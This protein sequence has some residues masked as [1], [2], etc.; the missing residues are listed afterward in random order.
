MKLKFIA[1]VMICTILASLCGCSEYTYL[2]TVKDESLFGDYSNESETVKKQLSLSDD[3]TYKYDIYQNNSPKTEFHFDGN[4]SYQ[5]INS[6]ITRIELD[7]ISHFDNGV[8]FKYKNLIG[9]YTSI[10]CDFNDAFTIPTPRDPHRFFIFDGKNTAT[11]NSGTQKSYPY[12]I[13]DD[14]IWFD[15]ANDKNYKPTYYIVDGG[16]F[17]VNTALCMIK[18]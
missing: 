11:L 12:K 17:C 4:Y 10:E 9:Y 6:D 15:Y 16:V 14:I 13:K 3:G 8:I 18:E 5:I 7:N 1:S 2:Y